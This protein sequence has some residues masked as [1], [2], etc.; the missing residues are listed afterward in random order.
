[1]NTDIMVSLDNFILFDT[2]YSSCDNSGYIGS[3]RI[4]TFTSKFLLGDNKLYERY[5]GLWVL[6]SVLVDDKLI[7]DYSFEAVNLLEEQILILSAFD[8]EA[9]IQFETLWEYFKL[10]SVAELN[11]I[12]R[13]LTDRKIEG[14]HNPLKATYYTLL[15]DG[16]TVLSFE[17]WEVEMNTLHTKWLFCERLRLADQGFSKDTIEDY[18][19]NRTFKE[20]LKKFYDDDIQFY[21]KEGE[22][23]SSVTEMVVSDSVMQFTVDQYNHSIE[24]MR[25]STGLPEELL[26]RQIT[27]PLSE[28]IDL[29]LRM[30]HSRLTTN[31]VIHHATVIHNHH[32]PISQSRQSESPFMPVFEDLT[33]YVM[34]EEEMYQDA[35]QV[36]ADTSGLETNEF[37]PL[38]TTSLNDYLDWIREITDLP[39]DEVVDYG[40]TVYNY[41]YGTQE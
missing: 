31:A 32:H 38:S 9:T 18:L 22:K 11:E 37:L 21:S 15:D 33:D 2:P 7:T 27:L 39:E 29:M 16:K 36:I 34:T 1:M 12:S 17:D 14:Y 10:P 19:S 25:L 40:T 41:H 6:K 35:L 23:D 26:I 28:Y 5:N 13:Q 24:E 3:P 30:S 4:K 20:F 8:K